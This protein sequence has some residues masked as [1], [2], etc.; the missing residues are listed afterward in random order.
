MPRLVVAT[1]HDDLAAALR[2]DCTI[3]LDD[4]SEVTP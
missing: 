1:S 4:A 3:A 2:P